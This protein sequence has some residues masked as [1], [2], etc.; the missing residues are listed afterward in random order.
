VNISLSDLQIYATDQAG[1]DIPVSLDDSGLDEGYGKAKL[2]FVPNSEGSVT[3][4]AGLKNSESQSEQHLMVSVK[5]AP[6]ARVN[7]WPRSSSARVGKSISVPFDTNLDIKDD[8]FYIS[9]DED[10]NNT[11]SYTFKGNVLKFTPK[12]A[13]KYTILSTVDGKPIEGRLP[14]CTF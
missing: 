11:S 3:I 13:T 9:V 2:V 1:N 8:I 10:G 14:H 5:P 4:R 7:K 6:Y 12:K